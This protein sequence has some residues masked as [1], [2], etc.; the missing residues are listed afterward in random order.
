MELKP[1]TPLLLFEGIQL[2]SYLFKQQQQQQQQLLLTLLVRHS[3][4][5]LFVPIPQKVFFSLLVAKGMFI[6][7]TNKQT[8][9]QTNL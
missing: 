5:G 7:Q 8:N 6:Q 3:F 1:I 2:Y 9:K 4:H